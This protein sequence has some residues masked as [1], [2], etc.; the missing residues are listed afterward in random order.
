MSYTLE[1][2]ADLNRL[3]LIEAWKVMLGLP[4][5]PH[6]SRN[7]MRLIISWQIQAKTARSDVRELKSAIRSLRK[8]VF[9]NEQTHFQP[10]KR[11]ISLSRGTR[12]SR[13][14]QGQTYIVDVL[15]K[16]YTF[17]GKLFTSLSQIAKAITGS[18]RSGPLFFG[19][20]K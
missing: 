10:I 5:P 17:D 4:L 9:C 11:K 6:T 7:M 14:W 20:N 15:D 3:A 1:E 18:H 13:D 12:L 19:V 2:L 16:G 8:T